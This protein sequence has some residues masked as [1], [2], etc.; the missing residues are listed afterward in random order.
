MAIAEFVAHVTTHDTL[1]SLAKSTLVKR[2]KDSV[3]RF[4]R[5]VVLGPLGL[6]V[7]GPVTNDILSQVQFHT[8]VIS[9]A[10][11]DMARRGVHDLL[12]TPADPLAQSTLTPN[13]SQAALLSSAF[14]QR[15]GRYLTTAPTVFEAIGRA[16]EALKATTMAGDLATDAAAAGFLQTPAQRLAFT[17]MVAALSTQAKI[18]PAVAQA[19]HKL[20]AQ[21]LED[22][23]GKLTADQQDFLR[24]RTGLRVDA[25]DRSTLVPAFVA[26][27]LVD[28]VMR[29]A[30]AGMD[31]EGRAKIEGNLDQKLEALGN[32]ALAAVQDMLTG[33]NRSKNVEEALANMAE[34]VAKQAHIEQ[35]LVTRMEAATMGAMGKANDWVAN[36]LA[37]KA[38]ALSKAASAK[39]GKTKSKTVKAAAQ[40]AAL[41]ANVFSD[42]GAAANAEAALSMVNKGKSDFLK[43]LVKD[44]TG[45]VDSN[46]SV[47]DLIKQVGQRVSKARQFYREQ[48]PT[49]IAKAFSKVPS[50][51]Q[52]T[53]MFKT[54]AKTGL[55]SLVQGD[56]FAAAFDTALDDSKRAAE[57]ARIE[58]ELK[59]E[60]PRTEGR[61]R[62]KAKLLAEY[63]TTGV[64]QAG[65]LRNADAVA[66]LLDDSVSGLTAPGV[67]EQSKVVVDLVD[68][69]ISLYAVDKVP[70]AE[71]EAMRQLRS[72]EPEGTERVLGVLKHQMDADKARHTGAARFNA[73][74]GYIPS[75]GAAGGSLI[76][77]DTRD[78]KNLT[79]KGYRKVA[80][81]KGTSLFNTMNMAY[82]Y[83]PVG[84]A[85]FNQGII[86]NARM[87]AGGVDQ[88]TGFAMGFPTAGRITQKTTV[89][90]LAKNAHLDSS[91]EALLAVYDEKG[92]VVAF[93]R[94]IDPDQLERLQPSTNVLA[95]LGQWMGRQAEEEMAQ[96]VNFDA[97]AKVYEMWN[98]GKHRKGEFVNVLDAKSYGNDPV[99]KDALRILPADVIKHAE[100]LF[101]TGR[102]M[103]RKD[104]LEDVFGYRDASLGDAWTGNSRWSPKTQER[105]RKLAEMYLGD[106]A[107]RLLVQGEERW[108]NLVKDA[109]T[110]IV[111][112]SVI[113]PAANF[114]AN[115]FQMLARGVPMSTIARGLRDKTLEVDFYVKTHVEQM[116][117]AVQLMA[118]G[119]K[120]TNQRQKLEARIQAIEDSWRRLS[121]WPLLAAG[122]FG[123]ISDAGIGR[124][125]I[126]LSEGKLQAYIEAKTEKLPPA[127]QR[128]G[129]W[130]LITKDTALFQGLQKSMEYGDFLAKAIVYDHHLTKGKTKAEALGEITDEFVNYDRHPGRVRGYVEDLGLAWFYNYKL[131]IAKTAFRMLRKDPLRVALLAGMGLP[132]TELPVT[133]NVFTKAVEGTLGH[134]IGPGMLFSSP[135]LNP[136][137]AAMQ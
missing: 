24:G 77:A 101:G 95:M 108:K 30:L 61:I 3:I 72:A 80:D 58:G 45:R 135:G 113:V 116:D 35:N 55:A 12:V 82:Y 50:E 13:D 40:T 49:V 62:K 133:E 131:R 47:Y 56:N 20:Y 36:T 97:V 99:L 52:S 60:T 79:R 83:T 28:P 86:Q 107:F 25:H 76:V 85:P 70:A 10:Q 87:T 37:D 119:S 92:N 105:V 15:V 120:D 130:A 126:L 54:I 51:E 16:T 33:A 109:K 59:K 128:A 68:Q 125:E 90:R 7:K 123:S 110:L 74:K 137:V 134:S 48:L 53:T 84:K 27:G 42:A 19:S 75:D 32:N 8:E 11:A 26:L 102:F 65:L 23:D 21:A 9:A 114:V 136:W 73:W 122:E 115:I 38:Q 118:L 91:R 63:M 88:S 44:L 4:L 66:N 64:V 112:K 67:A 124:D 17:Q 46:A 111:V 104:M 98:T 94:S 106:D 6:D 103:V 100:S 14:E 129:K 127:M 31:T 121:I 39:A 34:M 117:L 71:L 2:I 18:A 29:N 69:L 43:G 132:G 22:L 41:V 1:R 5:M 78:H 89:D 96:A 93:E 81:Y 57:I